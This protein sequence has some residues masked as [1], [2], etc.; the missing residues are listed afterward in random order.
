M[1]NFSA[2]GSTIVPPPPPPPPK[3]ALWEDFV[4]IFY[5]PSEVFRRRATAGFFVPMLIV[6]LLVGCIA[7][8]NSGVMQPLMDAEFERGMRL[9]AAKDPRVNQ[10]AMERFRSFGETFAKIGGFVVPPLAIL[11]TGLFLWLIGK[12]VD[13]KQSLGAAMMVSAYAYTVRVVEMVISGVQGLLMDPESLNSRFKLTFGPARF[14]DPD[15]SSPV[16]LAI[17]G[18]LDLFTIWLTVLLAIGL[19]VTG[20]IPRAQAFAAGAMLWVAGGLF[21]LFSALRM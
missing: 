1:S 2:P 3:T 20:K 7:L 12:F 19:A 16:L 13:A 17:V 8:A 11:A 5:A 15:L 9:A 21:N 10:E 4:D 18:R 14:L 6:T